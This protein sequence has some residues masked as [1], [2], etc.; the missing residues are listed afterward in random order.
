MR[1][2]CLLELKTHNDIIATTQ[3]CFNFPFDPLRLTNQMPQTCM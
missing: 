3:I 2:P 1:I